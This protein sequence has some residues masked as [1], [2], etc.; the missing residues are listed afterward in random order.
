[1]EK[2]S[3]KSSAFS[4]SGDCPLKKACH[5]DP[6]WSILIWISCAWL[7]ECVQKRAWPW[8][9]VRK[10]PC[11]HR[12]A[13]E[14]SSQTDQRPLCPNELPSSYLWSLS[15]CSCVFEFSP[16]TTKQIHDPTNYTIWHALQC[17]LSTYM[18]QKDVSITELLRHN[19]GPG[20]FMQVVN[21]KIRVLSDVFYRYVLNRYMQHACSHQFLFNSM[22]FWIDS[23]RHQIH[24]KNNT[25]TRTRLSTTPEQ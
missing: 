4:H 1:M 6:G 15:L 20:C 17:Y 9:C 12:A 3:N 19:Y 24:C 8:E 16:K 25:I 2:L 7:W 5:A 21:V 11:A 23:L 22:L 14:R 18:D 10:R 13:T